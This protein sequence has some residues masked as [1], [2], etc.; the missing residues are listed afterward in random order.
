M[1]KA[2]KL[3]VQALFCDKSPSGEM[4]TTPSF[5]KLA[6]WIILGRFI[7]R[8]GLYSDNWLYTILALLIYILLGMKCVPLFEKL[9]DGKKEQNG[10]SPSI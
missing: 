7:D 9:I 4:T 1:I 3:I 10:G 6:F 8:P 5:S 2:I